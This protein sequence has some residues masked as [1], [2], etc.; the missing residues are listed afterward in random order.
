MHKH[1]INLYFHIL[2]VGVGA[3]TDRD[4][5]IK[6]SV[7]PASE[8]DTN[9]KDQATVEAALLDLK[10]SAEESADFTTG[11]FIVST[12]GASVAR[13][14]VCGNDMC[15]VGETEKLCQADC[16]YPIKNVESGVTKKSDATAPIPIM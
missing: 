15:E 7:Q 6:F 1:R 12:E 13:Q 10:Y 3:D 9:G 2:Q 4:V 11:S 14:G 8:T 5:T 16:S